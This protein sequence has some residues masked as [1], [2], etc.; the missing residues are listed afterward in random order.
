MLLASACEKEDVG[1]KADG[2][3]VTQVLVQ[4][5]ALER[6]A[7]GDSNGMHMLLE[8]LSKSNDKWLK[9]AAQAAAFAWT[10]AGRLLPMVES[11]RLGPSSALWEVAF[12]QI[13]VKCVD[14]DPDVHLRVLTMLRGVAGKL[15]REQLGTYLQNTL[16]NS[17]KSRKRSRK[18]A[19]RA[20][21]E[22]SV[23]AMWWGGG[24]AFFFLSM[25]FLTTLYPPFPTNNNSISSL[26]R[27]SIAFHLQ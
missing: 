9:N 6:A 14:F 25:V 22:V 5:M 18:Q 3:L 4:T 10:L 13:L 12:D 24:G 21:G 16:Y 15:T 1:R 2:V 23:R 17:R 11:G 26:W 7:A 8:A 19:K 27:R 20:A